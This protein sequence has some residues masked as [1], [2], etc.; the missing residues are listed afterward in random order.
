VSWLD[1]DEP[2]EAIEEIGRRC[3]GA[4]RNILPSAWTFE[5]SRVL[6]FGCG[7]GRTLRQFRNEAQVAS[8][9]GCDI[10]ASSVEWLRQ[11]WSPPFHVTV[12]GEEPPLPYPDEHFDLVM[13]ISVFTHLTDTWGRWLLEIRRVMKPDAL[14]VATFLGQG[15]GV[16]LAG[17]PWHEDWDEDRIGMNLLLPATGWD[18][19]GPAVF[20]SRWWLEEHWGRAFEILELRPDGLAAVPG[21]GQGMLLLR[22]RQGA[23]TVAGLEEP[24]DDPRET[25]ALRHNREQLAVEIR[26]LAEEVKGLRRQAVTL[27]KERDDANEWRRDAVARFEDAQAAYRALRAAYDTR[28]EA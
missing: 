15:Y 28:S 24:G 8:F 11:H 27:A 14:F 5:G 20:H 4:V 7:A 25:A 3:A 1:L 22:K 18:A 6:D 13:A 9:H 16:T 17:P 23:L 10:D 2:L 19:G 26:A 21:L 12:T